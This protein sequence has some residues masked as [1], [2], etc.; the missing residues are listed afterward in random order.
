MS[1]ETYLTICG[2]L[3]GTPELRFTQ[4]GVP[5]ANFTIAATPRVFDKQSN[6]W[7]DGETLFLRSTI[8]RT[9]AEIV[10]E[11]LMKG[12]RVIA[13]GRLGMKG[14]TTRDGEQRTAIEFEVDEIGES[15]RWAKLGQGKPD[16]SAQSRGAEAGSSSHPAQESAPEPLTE[17]TPF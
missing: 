1:E 6:E 3:V 13:K 16:A 12:S 15:L 17:P 7:K 9:Q 2:N 11:K 14:F 10:A 4:S 8:W 5:V